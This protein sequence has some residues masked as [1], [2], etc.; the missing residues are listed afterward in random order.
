MPIY[1]AVGDVPNEGAAKRICAN[2]PAVT[3]KHG[4]TYGV[5]EMPGAV[6]AAR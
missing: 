1:L 5:F 2:D 3:P 6:A 4:F